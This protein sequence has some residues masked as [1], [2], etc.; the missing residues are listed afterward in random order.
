MTKL[1][2]FAARLLAKQAASE[3]EEDSKLPPATD[4]SAPSALTLDNV[5][6]YDAAQKVEND[7]DDGNDND[8]NNDNDEEDTSHNFMDLKALSKIL[9]DNPGRAEDP[10][11]QDILNRMRS[12]FQHPQYQQQQQSPDSQA[13]IRAK[14]AKVLDNDFSLEKVAS[15]IKGGKMK[16]IVVLTGAGVR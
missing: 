10:M 13:K 4:N 5:A 3:E 12:Q 11:I 15:K 1:E 9:E 7:D 14:M 6:A 8:D 16:K 2:S